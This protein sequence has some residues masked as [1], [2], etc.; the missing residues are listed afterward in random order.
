M[1]MQLI[2]VNH[3][4]DSALKKSVKILDKWLPRIS[5]K[6]WAGQLSKEGLNELKDQLEEVKTRQTEITVLWAHQHRFEPIVQIG[7]IINSNEN[8][9]RIGKRLKESPLKKMPLHGRYILSLAMIASLFHDTGKVA[10]ETQQVYRTQNSSHEKARHE[11]VSGA[12]YLDFAQSGKSLS[13]SKQS[14]SNGISWCKHHKAWPDNIVDRIIYQSIVSHHGLPTSSDN[15]AYV[16]K[17][18]K[19][20]TGHTAI[21]ELTNS[22]VL[23]ASWNARLQTAINHGFKDD[24][25]MDTWLDSRPLSEPFVYFMTRLILMVADAAESAFES[26]DEL[27]QQKFKGHVRYQVADANAPLLDDKIYAKSSRHVLLSQHL[28]GVCDYARKAAHLIFCSEPARITRRPL[29][30]QKSF[31]QK[32]SRFYWQNR[33]C[34]TIRQFYTDDNYHKKGFFGCVTSQTG[35]G[36]TQ[37]SYLIMSA[38]SASKPRFTLALGQGALAVQQGLEYRN[39]VGLSKDE[40]A[41]IVGERFQSMLKEES[42]HVDNPMLADIDSFIE[43]AEQEAV[44]T[45][46]QTNDIYKALFGGSKKQAFLNTPVTVMTIDH[47]IGAMNPNRGSFIPAAL[48][49]ATCDLVLDEIDSFSAV[50]L[51][52]I[53]R[54][55]YLVGLFGNKVLLSSATLPP[56]LASGLH[57]MYKKGYAAFQ[58]ATDADDY[59]IGLFNDDDVTGMAYVIP[60]KELDVKGF[61]GCYSDFHYPLTQCKDLTDSA[62]RKA[63]ALPIEA[64]LSNTLSNTKSKDEVKHFYDLLAE[65]IIEH[66]ADMASEHHTYVPIHDHHVSFG[67]VRLNRVKDII[68]LALAF[69]RQTLHKNGWDIKFQVL[70]SR[71]DRKVRSHIQTSLQCV[72]KRDSDHGWYDAYT[73]HH[74]P[75]KDTKTL[76]VVLCSSV[77][78]TGLDYDFDWAILEPSS[79][80]SIIQSAGRVLRHRYL[81]QITKPNIGLLD[82]TIYSLIPK[83]KD[84][85]KP[86]G[87]YRFTP[88]GSAGI[89]SL[90]IPNL[91]DSPEKEYE[92]KIN[93]R[94]RVS[95]PASANPFMKGVK[96]IYIDSMEESSEDLTYEQSIT[97]HSRLSISPK[98]WADQISRDVLR[99][100]FGRSKET[101]PLSLGCF[102]GNPNPLITDQYLGITLR[103][104]DNKELYQFKIDTSGGYSVSKTSISGIERGASIPPVSFEKSKMLIYLPKQD[105]YE[106]EMMSIPQF[107]HPAIGAM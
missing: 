90:S 95:E 105:A 38:L 55:V 53:G 85:A 29:L 106:I 67:F 100:L 50:A 15:Y 93:K 30:L 25:I 22:N 46:N 5:T 42:K 78:E 65:H 94:R 33:S 87:I 20:D 32:G 49:I 3:S 96:E 28:S 51:H 91:I 57:E 82:T 52:A 74:T 36:K 4:K 13:W 63:Q 19:D 35:S 77:I 98:T 58:S 83:G 17:R 23:D 75:I 9:A 47:L 81:L 84:G 18:A 102:L 89:A 16:F 40:L 72:L 14:F 34:S 103:S 54:L 37:A 8:W 7:R 71:M 73:K 59:H 48:R 41:I 66:C 107:F 6:V 99:Q 92:P 27:Q 104:Q 64:A 62:R 97:A 86:C 2:V 31:P 76:V 101:Q 70:H 79:D 24:L 11:V 60:A 26:N 39:R 80:M 44:R 10:P 69:D 21:S 43:I 1:A 88:P 12:V 61:E 56:E 68:Q 45:S